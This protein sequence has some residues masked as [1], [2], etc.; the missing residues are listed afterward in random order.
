MFFEF[1][2][3]GSDQSTTDI[4]FQHWRGRF[5]TIVLFD[6]E[7]SDRL[8]LTLGVRIWPWTWTSGF[9]QDAF[10]LWLWLWRWRFQLKALLLLQVEPFRE[11]GPKRVDRQKNLWIVHE[12]AVEACLE[13]WHL[14]K[15]P[16]HGP[17]HPPESAGMRFWWGP[18]TFFP[19]CAAQMP[20]N[21]HE[22][23]LLVAF[24]ARAFVQM[25]VLRK[26]DIDNVF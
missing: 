23:L 5:A 1:P 21:A 4:R 22:T 13:G 15:C 9:V 7:K 25:P 11:A 17:Q 2:N 6:F 3:F 14:L 16:P 12:D 24:G 19:L 10:Q 20:A 8:I 18:C 26:E